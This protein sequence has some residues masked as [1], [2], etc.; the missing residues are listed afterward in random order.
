MLV[1][2][3][4]ELRCRLFAYVQLMPLHPK[5]PPSLASFKS[6]LVLSFWYRLTQVV[7]NKRP[8]SG[9]S[10]SSSSSMPAGFCRHFMTKT[11]PNVCYCDVT[12]SRSSRV[13]SASDCR[14]RGPR[15]ESHRRR[16]CLSPQPLRYASWDTG[17]ALLL[18]CLGPVPDL[19]GCY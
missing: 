14:V 2:L 17:C 3:G 10:S 6:R 8:L 12:A 1:W 7:V 15:F 9:C 13:V 5:S 11:K 4:S 18:H 19:G 16:W